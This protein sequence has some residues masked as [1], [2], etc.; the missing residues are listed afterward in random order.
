MFYVTTLMII[1]LMWF[2]PFEENF[3]TGIEV[4]NE[5]TVIFLLYFM[6]T[7]SDW[8][9]SSEQRYDLAWLFIAIVTLYISVHLFFLAKG[10]FDNLRLK[11]K[12]RIK[13]QKLAASGQKKSSQPAITL[14]DVEKGGVERE[15]Q[16][17][18]LTAMKKKSLKRR[19]KK[20]Q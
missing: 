3:Y 12:Q 19:N 7:F 1:Y 14:E 5:I 11:S 13:K 4:F 8:V 6:L 16:Y 17:L 20:R 15:S 9:P 10:V 18:P 2:K